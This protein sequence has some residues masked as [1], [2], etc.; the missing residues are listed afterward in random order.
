VTLLRGGSFGIGLR[1]Y[2]VTVA[3]LVAAAAALFLVLRLARER[4]D[5]PMGDPFRDA[6]RYA[7]GRIATAWPSEPSVRGEV[8]ALGEARFPTA[9]YRW[10]GGLMAAS[11]DP[12]APPLSPAERDALARS[13]MLQRGEECF[14]GRCALAFA[15][16]GAGTPAGYLVIGPHRPPEGPRPPPRELMPVV[17]VLIGLGVAA[18]LLG[19]SLARPLDRLARTAH[20]L[21]SGDLSARTG[22]SRHDEVGAVARAFDEM[23]DR[24]VALIHAQTELVANVAHELR[25]PLARIRVALDLADEGDPTVARASLAEI[26]E[27]LSELE[28]LVADVLA[29]ARMELAGTAGTGAPP[30]RSAPLDVTEVILAATDRLRHRHPGRRVDV[31]LPPVLPVVVADA[32]L[33]RRALDNLLDNARKYSPPETEILVRA[34]ARDGRV[35]VEVVDRGDGIAPEDLARLFT[36]FFRADPSRSRATGGVGLGL[37]LSRRIVE[38]HGGTLAARSAPGAGTTMTVSLPAAP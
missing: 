23:A 29:S 11:S 21:G 37:A 2:V 15:L 20:A 18:V 25:T 19:S 32:V 8:A 30:L 3:A 38:A 16:P 33:L 26:G 9:V 24:V 4:R 28:R 27:D 34:A 17:L 10:D 6:A 14:P 12:P 22:I 31:E 35:V 7:A 1:I 5:P 13:G 36:P